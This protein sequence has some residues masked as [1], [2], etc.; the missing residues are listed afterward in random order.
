MAWRGLG[1]AFVEL[2]RDAEAESAMT[3]ALEL[4]PND[5]AGFFA[6][7]D[8]YF[9]HGRYGE[10]VEVYEQM[11]S[12][13]N[14]GASAYNSQGAAYYMMGEFEKAAEAYR[15][16]VATEPMAAAYSNIGIMYF[17]NGQFEDAAIMYREAIALAPENP[18]WW[19]NLADSMR[20]IDGKEEDAE[21]AYRKAADLT[22]ALSAGKPARCGIIDQS[23][24]L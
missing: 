20:E 4:D 18:V 17:Y 12:H 21:M 6:L 19:G 16:V 14:A 5:L 23:G 10:A 24:S 2:E 22:G 8:F 11:A 7:G 9:S 15:Q 13:P 1:Q 3:R